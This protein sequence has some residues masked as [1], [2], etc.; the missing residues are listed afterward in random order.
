MGKQYSYLLKAL[1]IVLFLAGC[2]PSEA[3]NQHTTT[4]SESPSSGYF[5]EQPFSRSY[6]HSADLE[7]NASRQ[8]AITRAVQVVSPSV[9]SVSVTGVRESAMSRDPFFDFFWNPGYVQEFT[10]MGSGFIISED[11]HVLTNEH[12]VGRNARN[13]QIVLSSGRSYDATLL[14]RD[15]FADLALLKI[16]SDEKFDHVQFGNSDDLMVGEWAIAVGNPFGLFEDGQP[17]V[18]VGVISAL[19]RDFRPIP[20]EPRVYLN[21]IQTDAAINRGNSGGPLVN[22]MGEVIGINTFIYTGG[23]SSGFVG[24]GF[25]IPSNTVIRILNMLVESG[26]VKLDY[27][28]GFEWAGITRGLAVRYNLPTIQGLLVVSVNRDGPAYEAGILPGDIVLRVGSEPIYS[29]NHA[30]ALFREYNE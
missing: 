18:T 17:S 7:I 20:Q 30:W 4:E 2:E 23:T 14:G 3:P 27:D 9:V 22:S 24:L 10:N 13:I 19:K 8:S 21:M 15:E 29:Q 16:N 12:V 6:D 28:A 26:E 1:V 5:L 25:A 11:G